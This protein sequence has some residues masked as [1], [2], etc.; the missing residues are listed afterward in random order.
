MP[1]AVEQIN[2]SLHVCFRGFPKVV[3]VS[4][5]EPYGHGF[6]EGRDGG[7][8]YACMCCGYVFD[9]LWDAYQEAYSPA[10]SVEILACR[11]DGDGDLFEFWRESSDSCERDVVQPIV[12]FVRED[13]DLVL[14]AQIPDS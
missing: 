4:L 3:S 2:L 11:S 6:L 14:D 8:T 1:D 13:E 9:E 5:L 10:C 7:E 12:D